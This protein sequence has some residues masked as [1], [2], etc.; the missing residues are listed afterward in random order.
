MWRL[1]P[2][3]T[4]EP[5]AAPTDTKAK[6]YRFLKSRYFCISHYLFR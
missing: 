3:N 2:E 6:E 1:T 4:G 5:V